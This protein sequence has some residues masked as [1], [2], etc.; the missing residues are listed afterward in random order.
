MEGESGVINR[1]KI[2]PG[3]FLPERPWVKNSYPHTRRNIHSHMTRGI[4]LTTKTLEIREMVFF[5]LFIS[6]EGFDFLKFIF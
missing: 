4:M 2:L 1:P 6:D 5:G 3:V